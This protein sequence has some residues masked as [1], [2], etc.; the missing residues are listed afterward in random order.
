[1]T[2]KTEKEKKTF[3]PNRI[4]EKNKAPNILNPQEDRE[5]EN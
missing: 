3:I 5:K 4:R 2:G 1:M